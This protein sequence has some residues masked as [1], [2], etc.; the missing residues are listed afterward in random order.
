MPSKCRRKSSLKKGTQAVNPVTDKYILKFIPQPD[1]HPRLGDYLLDHFGQPQWTSFRAAVAFVKYSGVRHVAR[2]LREFSPRADVRISVGIDLGGSSV[3]GLR[4]LLDSL[5]GRGQIWVFHND[6]NSTFH[7]KVYVFKSEQRADILVGSG[8]LTEG[9]LYTNYEASLAISL[10]LN[11]SLQKNLLNDIESTLDSWSHKAP[12]TSVLLT[13][14]ILDQLISNGDVVPEAQAREEEHRARRDSLRVAGSERVSLFQRL[15]VPRAPVRP[16]KISSGLEEEP[17]EEELYVEPPTRVAAQGGRFIGFLMTL[18]R[19]DVGFG[20][21]TA[22]A[23]RRIPEIFIP[24]AARD[25]DPEFWGWPDLYTPDPDWTEPLDRD[26]R[27]KMDRFDV[28]VR[29]GGEIISVTIWYNPDKH[30]IR[31]RGEALRRAGN[32]GDILRIER[33]SGEQGFAYYVEIIPQGTSQYA[34]YLAL[35]TREVR[36]SQK[37]WGYY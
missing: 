36:N 37:R 15:P 22:G 32:V 21:T 30:D 20:Q 4:A 27:G 13:H 14:E 12:G 28:P 34:E 25:H 10:D 8:N 6:N 2:A 9:G 17:G 23:S 5:G 11:D 26:G 1:Y 16:E 3:E 24:L 7:P 19:T 29:L 33:A 31:I 18:Q 35:C